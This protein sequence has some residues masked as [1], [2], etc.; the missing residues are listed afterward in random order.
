ML[1]HLLKP[2]FSEEGANSLIHKKVVYGKFIK[3]IS[4]ADGGCGVATSENI[5]EFV[6]G[7]SEEPIL[8]FVLQW[9]IE[10]CTAVLTEKVVVPKHNGHSAEGNNEG[11]CTDDYYHYHSHYVFVVYNIC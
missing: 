1:I 9:Y 11:N 5:W 3:Y 8:G 7:V 6:T 4:E 10:V 2:I